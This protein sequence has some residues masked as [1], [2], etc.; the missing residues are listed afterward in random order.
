MKEKT[1]PAGWRGRVAEIDRRLAEIETERHRLRRLRSDI[2]AGR[3]G[4]LK[5]ASG[6]GTVTLAAWTGRDGLTYDE[7][8]HKI[9]RRRTAR[10]G[11]VDM[12]ERAL[13]AHGI[14]LPPDD[15]THPAE[16]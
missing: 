7:I 11:D 16:Q 4:E 12:V 1:T 10:P 5:R 2:C 14:T 8:V 6:T 9:A 15:D 13:L 3:L